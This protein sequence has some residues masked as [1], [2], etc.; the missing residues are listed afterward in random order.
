[1][2]HEPN[3]LQHNSTYATLQVL[4]YACMR[5]MEDGDSGSATIVDRTHSSKGPLDLPG[6][7]QWNRQRLAPARK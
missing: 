2:H 3:M 1:M 4:D 6:H 7:H 5:I